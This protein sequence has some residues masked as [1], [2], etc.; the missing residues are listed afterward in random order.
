MHT[1]DTHDVDRLCEA[2]DGTNVTVPHEYIQPCHEAQCVDKIVHLLMPVKHIASSII[3]TG[4]SQHRLTR[5]IPTYMPHSSKQIRTSWGGMPINARS[6][7]AMSMRLL[8][9]MMDN[10]AA[11]TLSDPSSPSYEAMAYSRSEHVD[12][13]IQALQSGFLIK[14]MDGAASNENRNT[15]QMRTRSLA[16][17]RM[18]V[19]RADILAQHLPVPICYSLHKSTKRWMNTHGVTA[20]DEDEIGVEPSECSRPLL[21]PLRIWLLL[22]GSN[23]PWSPDCFQTLI[24]TLGS[25]SF[26]RHQYCTLCGSSRPVLR[27]RIWTH[28]RVGSGSRLMSS[29]SVR[30]SIT[31]FHPSESLLESTATHIE[32]NH[33]LNLVGATPVDEL[34]SPES[35]WSAI[36]NGE[37]GKQYALAAHKFDSDVLHA[38]SILAF[39]FLIGPTPSTQ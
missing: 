8:Q 26:P 38:S 10:S 29:L 15:A 33:R 5:N 30:R 13:V 27:L 14:S 20:R 6:T 21:A 7:L 39:R 25:L 4:V 1:H 31:I 22:L 9:V 2:R 16:M 12:F 19:D 24:I 34:V 32:A 17:D 28:L 18:V 36:A 35:E 37:T 11:W 3:D 23:L